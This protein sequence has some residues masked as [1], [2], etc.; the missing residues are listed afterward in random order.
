[1][2]LPAPILLSGAFL[3]GSIPFGLLVTRWSAGWDLRRRGSGNIGAANVLREAGP[4]PA[5]ATLALDAGKG[6][7]AVLL[8][9]AASAHGSPV[10]EAAGLAAMAGH[11]FSPWLRFR[12]GKGVAT[13]AG[14]FGIVQPV[15]TGAAVIVFAA[16]VAWTRRVSAGSIGAALAF[17]LLVAATGAAGRSI[18]A[19]ALASL[20]IL[21][22]HRANMHRLRDGTEPRIG[23]G[24]FGGGAESA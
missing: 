19:S 1:M 14:A 17:P 10:A 4:I 16:L 21:W 23:R 15:A 11:V 13:G 22:S 3:L 18:A 12:G 2:S 5:L 24:R 7:L 8:A 20:L 6:C 9:R